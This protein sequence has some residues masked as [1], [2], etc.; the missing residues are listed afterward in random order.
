MI[1]IDRDDC[2][3]KAL[4]DIFSLTVVSSDRFAEEFKK[5][6]LINFEKELAS[7]GTIGQE[8]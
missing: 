6:L 8:Q 4:S 3:T 7:V 1:L 5:I 2:S